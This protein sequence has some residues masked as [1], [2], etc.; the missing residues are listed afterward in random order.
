MGTGLEIVAWGALGLG[1]VGTVMGSQGETEAGIAQASA[2]E[3]NA[4]QEEQNAKDFLE[5]A[6]EQKRRAALSARAAIVEGERQEQLHREVASRLIS[7]Q[8]GT[9]ANNNVLVD[10]GTAMDIVNDTARGAAEDIEVIRNAAER[11]ALGFKIEGADRA[12][13]LEKAASNS[14]ANA[15][16][17]Q[18]EAEDATR[19]GVS[20]SNSSLLS[21]LGSLGLQA[22][23][24][25]GGPSTGSLAAPGASTA[26]VGP[27]GGS[28]G[29]GL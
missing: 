4:I 29:P 17:L 5:A 22:F 8:R 20:R 1:A 28:P 3:Y 25:F 24:A 19:A 9:I 16:L 21:G 15:I 10:V 14:E 18:F 13:A 11:E 26:F 7:T 2:A 6:E 27:P 12:Q 23:G